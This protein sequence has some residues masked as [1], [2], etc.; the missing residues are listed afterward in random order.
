MPFPTHKEFVGHPD[1]T[2]VSSSSLPSDSPSEEARVRNT[3]P[4][5]SIAEFAKDYHE[6]SQSSLPGATSCNGHC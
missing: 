3:Y 5:P 4:E 6:G 1:S 2:K